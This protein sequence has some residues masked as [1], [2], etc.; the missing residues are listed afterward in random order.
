MG[1]KSIKESKNMYQ[2]SRESSALTRDRA[3]EDQK[4]GADH[5]GDAEFPEYAGKRKEPPD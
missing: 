4:S 2:L 5:T 3:A 1:R